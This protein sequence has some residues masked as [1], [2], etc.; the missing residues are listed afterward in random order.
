MREWNELMSLEFGNPGHDGVV[1]GGII[2]SWT[3]L[4]LSRA[5][6]SVVLMEQYPLPHT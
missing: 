5:G 2:G 3:A 4:E 1:G 6:A